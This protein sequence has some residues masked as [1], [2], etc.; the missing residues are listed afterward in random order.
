MARRRAIAV[1]VPSRVPTGLIVRLLLVVVILVA[2]AAV[3]LSAAGGFLTYRIV[4]TWNTTENLA[5]DSFLLS[6][7]EGLS[8]TD[9]QGEEHA[10][11]LLRG[12]K[13]GPV[14]ILSH[15]YDSN[16]SEMLSLA[17]V[18][19]ERHFNVYLFNYRGVKPKSL[20]TDMGGRE[21][22]ILESAIESVLKQPGI[23]ATRV[24]LYG[25][26]IGGFASMRVAE[27][28]PTIRAIAVDN[29]YDRPVDMFNS[30]IDQ[31]LGSTTIFRVVMDAEFRLLNSGSKVPPL[32]DNFSKLDAIFKDFIS[33]RDTPPLAVI[34]EGFYNR[35]GQPK[36]LLVMDHTQFALMNG[37]EKKEYE[38]Q[39]GTFFQQHLPLRVD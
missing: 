24:G 14:I 29:V 25:K 8:F 31:T 17:T 18:L 26:N 23:N 20:S 34:T 38:D 2:V 5:P 33:G 7:Y 27:Q 28:N 13:G 12:L 36:Q 15:G 10:G 22:A 3:V 30:E 39:I 6:N 37:T 19:Q 21:T 35:A 1:A 4:T 9:K 11:W 16:R 32:S